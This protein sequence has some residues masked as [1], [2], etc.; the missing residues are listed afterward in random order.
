MENDYFSHLTPEPSHLHTG[1]EEHEHA[2]FRSLIGQLMWIQR[3]GVWGVADA[4]EAVAPTLQPRAD[5]E[6]VLAAARLSQRSL[7]RALRLCLAN[8]IGPSVRS[9]TRHLLATFDPTHQHAATPAD[10]AHRSMTRDRL[11]S[12]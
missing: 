11:A 10:C 3:Q 1:D 8:P 9:H 2:Q 4:H 5:L 7:A 6:A 12:D